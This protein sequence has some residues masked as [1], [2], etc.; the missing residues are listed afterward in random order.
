MPVNLRAEIANRLIKAE[1]EALMILGE[2]IV[3]DART[4]APVRK[5]TKGPRRKMGK[6]A[7]ASLATRQ[8]VRSQKT[9][10]S[11]AEYQKFQY[12]VLYG[13]TRVARKTSRKPLVIGR[14]K[15][16]PSNTVVTKTGEVVKFKRN[17]LNEVVRSH[18][19]P[20]R[21]FR[22]ANG[23]GIS[24]GRV[25]GLGN[26]SLTN[27]GRYELRRAVIREMAGTQRATIV[28]EAGQFQL[29]GRLK[30][31]IDISADSTA[32]RLIIEADPVDDRG[33]HYARYVEFPTSRTAAQPFLLPALKNSKKHV[34]RVFEDAFRRHGLKG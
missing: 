16:T 2:A 7:G 26:L 4:R 30:A 10:M 29:G 25:T 18:L 24:G 3:Q 11:N 28:N 9:R 13:R 23:L 6:L 21:R 34:R 33:H 20:T 14:F 1:A 17:K 15:S 12:A 8:F 19:P 5:L 22:P 32:N 27:R 31:S